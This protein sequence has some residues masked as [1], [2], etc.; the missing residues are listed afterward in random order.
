MSENILYDISAEESRH[1]ERVYR[2]LREWKQRRGCNARIHQLQRALRRAG[3]A[4]LADQLMNGKTRKLLSYMYQ[5]CY[6]LTDERGK[7][8]L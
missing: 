1:R 8:H 5:I 7:S 6:F 2:M 4:D 3:R